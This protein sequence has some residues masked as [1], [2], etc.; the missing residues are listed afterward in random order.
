[1]TSSNIPS[2][3]HHFLEMSVWGIKKNFFLTQNFKQENCYDC[4]H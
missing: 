2:K 4:E 3:D 1:M